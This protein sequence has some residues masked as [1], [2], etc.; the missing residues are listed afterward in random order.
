MRIVHRSAGAWEYP[1]VSMRE[2]K[3]GSLAGP[4][5]RSLPLA[6]YRRSMGM[7][8]P[9]P[10]VVQDRVATL[11]AEWARFIAPPSPQSNHD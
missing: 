5:C 7:I 6:R 2:G 11:G 8:P 4:D 9:Q 10:S 1:D 3:L